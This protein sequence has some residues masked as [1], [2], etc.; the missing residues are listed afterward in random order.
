MLVHTLHFNDPKEMYLIKTDREKE[1]VRMLAGKNPAPSQ[2]WCKII[3][4]NVVGNTV[5]KQIYSNPNFPQTRDKEWKHP[6]FAYNYPT[7]NYIAPPYVAGEISKQ[8]S[9]ILIQDNKPFRLAV[10]L[11]QSIQ[12]INGELLLPWSKFSDA[13]KGNYQLKDARI[14]LSPWENNNYLAGKGVLVE[15]VFPLN[16]SGATIIAA[17]AYIPET[18]LQETY[19][20]SLLS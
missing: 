1:I 7:N 14:C 12:P 2:A 6:L 10:D 20:N 3:D 17:S 15:R 4:I 9:N 18:K 13:V 5:S 16:S 19:N 8:N 11:N